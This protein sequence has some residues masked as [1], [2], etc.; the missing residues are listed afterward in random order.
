MA[1]LGRP[2]GQAI[3]HLTLLNLTGYETKVPPYSNML[4]LA[5]IS[6]VASHFHRELCYELAEVVNGPGLPNVVSLVVGGGG[7]GVPFK[8]VNDKNGGLLPAIFSAP[9]AKAPRLTCVRTFTASD[10]GKRLA[11]L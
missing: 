8:A 11:S 7:S 6:S 2:Q 9:H 5:G 10:E 3:T 1:G 4:D